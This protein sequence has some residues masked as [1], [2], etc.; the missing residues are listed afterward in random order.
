[1]V[2]AKVIGIFLLI[3]LIGF[4]GYFFVEKIDNFLEDEE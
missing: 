2:I 3:F 1:M 4:I